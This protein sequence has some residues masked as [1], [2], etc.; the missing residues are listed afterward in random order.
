MTVE[1]SSA[2]SWAAIEPA[3]PKPW[4]ATVALVEV[5]AEVAGRRRRS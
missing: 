1:P 2:M 4:T 3:L 5:H